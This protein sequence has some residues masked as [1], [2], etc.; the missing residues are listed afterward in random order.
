MDILGL[1]AFIFVISLINLPSTL[2]NLRRKINK[3]ENKINEGEYSMSNLLKEL[4][5]KRCKIIFQS[6]FSSKLL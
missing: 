6:D 4:E 1:L 5:G 3:I 2:N